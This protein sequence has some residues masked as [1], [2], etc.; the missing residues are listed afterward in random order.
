MNALLM[1]LLSSTPSSRLRFAKSTK[2]FCVSIGVLLRL[3]SEVNTW[4]QIYGR[5]GVY[6]EFRENLPA[7]D[8]LPEDMARKAIALG[9]WDYHRDWLQRLIDR[10]LEIGLPLV[11]AKLAKD[12]SSKD[13][14][15]SF[16]Y[17]Y[18]RQ[19]TDVPAP[20]SLAC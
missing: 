14:H 5:A 4:N 10:R 13:G 11:T 19:T 20:S 3:E 8:A 12:L 18:A 15:N 1:T 16:L 17:Y 7:F 9:V 6:L 2:T